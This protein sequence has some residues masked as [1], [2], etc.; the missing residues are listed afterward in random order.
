MFIR[1]IFIFVL[2][3]IFTIEKSEDK[4]IYVKNYIE[5]ELYKEIH[6]IKN[7]IDLTDNYKAEN[8]NYYIPICNNGNNIIN[9]SI[10]YYNCL[11]SGIMN[12]TLLINKTINENRKLNNI[13]FDIYF[14]KLNF[15]FNDKTYTLSFIF[16]LKKNSFNMNL[17][18]QILQSPFFSNIKNYFKDFESKIEIDYSN[19]FKKILYLNNENNIINEYNAILSLY[20][21]KPPYI[22][23]K[24]IF[25]NDE[26]IT[27]LKPFN[28]KL[29]NPIVTNKELK[30]DKLII[31]SEYSINY[32][33][34]YN[35]AEIIF[36]NFTYDGEMKSEKQTDGN[37]VDKKTQK[38][39]NEQISKSI[40]DK[41]NH[42]TFCA[43]N[44]YFN[45]KSYHCLKNL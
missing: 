5:N 37:I 4:L 16:N 26:K 27:Y 29:I 11:V 14:D 18:N 23:K 42:E 41:I 24:E 17:N 10:I 19:K 28:Y 34:N 43:Y 38:V 36:Y 3:F 30:V 44:E 6:Y 39:L 45:I 20:F 8:L 33:L 40:I 2:F 7:N 21:L 15:T 13:N 1:F 35:E 25:I 12:L 22:Y 32:D 9:N 31:Y